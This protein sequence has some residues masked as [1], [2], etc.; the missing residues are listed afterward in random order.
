MIKYTNMYNSK[1]KIIRTNTSS[2]NFCPQDKRLQALSTLANKLLETL[3]P[4]NPTPKTFD[5]VIQPYG[6]ED[7]LIWFSKIKLEGDSELVKLSQSA[8]SNPDYQYQDAEQESIFKSVFSSF[9]NGKTNWY[10]LNA[11]TICLTRNMC[12]MK[13]IKAEAE[14]PIPYHTFIKESKTNRITRDALVMAVA[15]DK[16]KYLAHGK[17]YNDVRFL[18]QSAL[19]RSENDV[20]DGYIQAGLNLF[21]KEHIIDCDEYSNKKSHALMLLNDSRYEKGEQFQ[22][23]NIL[24]LWGTKEV[25]HTTVSYTGNLMQ[26]KKDDKITEVYV[27][28]SPDSDIPI[29]QVNGTII[30]GIDNL[31]RAILSGNFAPAPLWWDEVKTLNKT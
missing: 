26:I 6:M 1:G 2:L 15:S 22:V 16:R 30:K 20:L 25:K 18:I 8:V 10:L 12:D 5:F 11:E 13:I 21:K 7:R 27:S 4:F 9:E 31:K 17:N 23:C 24:K 3:S 14:K 29:F 19:S 28:K